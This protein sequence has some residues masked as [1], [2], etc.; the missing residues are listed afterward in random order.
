MPY[1]IEIVN[2]CDVTSTIYSQAWE[3]RPS[4]SSSSAPNRHLPWTCSWSNLVMS[5]RSPRKQVAR[6]DSLWQ[7]SPTGWSMEMCYP[8]GLFWADATV[9]ADY[10][11]TTTRVNNVWNP[12]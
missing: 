7:Q 4:T 8:L 10:A 3:G 11:M 5:P 2:Y 12:W 9:T 1:N 6:S